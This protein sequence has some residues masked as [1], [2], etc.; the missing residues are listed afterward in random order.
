MPTRLERKGQPIELISDADLAVLN[1]L[2]HEIARHER[3][4]NFDGCGLCG[5]YSLTS[6]RRCE[7]LSRY[8]PQGAF[9]R[10]SL[11]RLERAGLVVSQR[12]WQMPIGWSITGEGD[13][14]LA[15]R[16]DELPGPL[17]CV[18]WEAESLPALEIDPE[19]TAGID[20]FDTPSVE[21]CCESCALDVLEE[22]DVQAIKAKREAAE[23]CAAITALSAATLAA[24]EALP[25][26]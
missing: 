3:R 4:C 13:G 8:H 7:P 21:G 2:D 18:C 15:E 12:R 20:R 17:C 22:T 23:R 11:K 10:S 1:G 5:H 26:E 25:D 6:G 19:L 24:I 14:F 9:P 16:E